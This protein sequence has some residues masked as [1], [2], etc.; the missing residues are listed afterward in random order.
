MDRLLDSARSGPMFLRQPAVAQIVLEE[1]R[2]PQ[3]ELH[4]FAI[5]P[6]H[7]HLLFTAEAE[8][9]PLLKSLKGRSARRVNQFMNM[10]GQSFW[11]DESYDR[12]VRSDE[13]FE[14]IRRY[15][16]L[17]PVKAGLALA[18]EEYPWS[19]AGA[20]LKSRAD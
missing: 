17:N 20:G 19:S 5:M 7:V 1:I 8:V 14:R 11:Q 4:A 13:E 9:A 15:I 12:W 10:T 3:Y 6:N 16:E 18:P 2:L